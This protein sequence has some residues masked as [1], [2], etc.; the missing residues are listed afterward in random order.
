MEVQDKYR[1]KILM[2]QNILRK[3]EMQTLFDVTFVIE[4]G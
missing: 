3:E 4:I 2:K 1:K